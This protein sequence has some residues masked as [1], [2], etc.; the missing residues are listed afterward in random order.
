MTARLT[1]DDVMEALRTAVTNGGEGKSNPGCEIGA[2]GQC[3]YVEN[4]GTPS[5]LV[6][7]ALAI[8]GVRLPRYEDREN[9]HG[10]DKL[11]ADSRD[12]AHTFTYEAEEALLTVQE[13]ADSGE[14]WAD[15]LNAY[16][17]Q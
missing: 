3:R 7:N 10:I 13:Y 16:D 17:Q 5:C 4:D 14:T 6:G 1:Y 2:S 9:E 11:L 12:L 15:V 8:L